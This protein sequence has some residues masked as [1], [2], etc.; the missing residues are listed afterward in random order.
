MYLYTPFNVSFSKNLKKYSV[1]SSNATLNQ[2]LS[3]DCTNTARIRINYAYGEGYVFF[4]EHI[5][6]LLEFLQANQDK[7]ILNGANV[8]TI[9]TQKCSNQIVSD[10]EYFLKASWFQLFISHQIILLID[11]EVNKAT[12]VYF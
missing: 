10:V 1:E 9:S 12:L 4:T 11:C 6:S 7:L 3:T 5:M 2:R 8:V